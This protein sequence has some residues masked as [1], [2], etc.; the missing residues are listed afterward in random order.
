MRRED[1]VEKEWEAARAPRVRKFKT[2]QLWATLLVVLAVTSILV[3]IDG[4]PRI[5]YWLLL[6]TVFAFGFFTE[7]NWRCP[8][9]HVQLGNPTILPVPPTACPRCSR[10]LS[11]PP[12]FR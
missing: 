6:G 7:I 12:R 9:C 3:G 4:W 1:K 8:Y 5:K 11:D 2:A 10:Q